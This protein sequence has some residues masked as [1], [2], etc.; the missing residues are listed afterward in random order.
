VRGL[1]ALLLTVVL[2]MP[3]RPVAADDGLLPSIQQIVDRGVL[4]IAVV[5][6]ARPPMIKRGADG[7]LSGFDVDLAS[8]IAAELGVE[9]KFVAAGPRREDIILTVAAGRADI[10]LSYLSESIDAGK[11]VLFSQPYMIEALTVFINRVKGVRL[12]E[13]CPRMSDLRVLAETENTLGIPSDG[14]FRTLLRKPDPNSAVRQFDS[15]ESLAAA[16]QSGEIVVSLQGEA[17]AKFYL[18]RNPAAAIKL[19]N[20][21]V[22]A[23]Q[24][25]VSIA[26]RPDATDLARCLDLYIVQRGAIIDL[27]SLIYR[28]DRSTY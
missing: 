3:W 26:V 7:K 16:V 2:T 17:A 5:D 12:Q 24:H 11:R 8:D 23:R 6:G 22:P 9:P 15:S 10:G 25:R 1:A 21:N 27:D 28:A 19:Q 18:S 4:T 13:D 14:P 20:C